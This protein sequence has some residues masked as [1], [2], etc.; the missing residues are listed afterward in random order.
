ME[1]A[2]KK[3]AASIRAA[4]ARFPVYAMERPPVNDQDEVLGPLAPHDQV[5]YDSLTGAAHTNFT[6][7]REGA[8]LFYRACYA[9]VPYDPTAGAYQD[10]WSMV[11]RAMLPRIIG[12]GTHCDTSH[13]PVYLGTKLAPQSAAVHV[14]SGS[15]NDR[16]PDLT[17][18]FVIVGTMG[19]E[20]RPPHTDRSGP[21]LVGWALSNALDLQLPTAYRT[22][23][24]TR[25]QNEMLIFVV[26]AFGALA[27]CC[28]V[29]VFGVLR[30]M[31]LR[32]LRPFLPWIAASVSGAA[33]LIAFLG[34]EM[35]SFYQ[36]KILQPQ[37]CLI[38]LGALLAAGLS[39]IRANQILLDE[40]NQIDAPAS[41]VND[42][43]VFISYAH[44][45]LAWVTQNVY[46]KFRD[47]KRN[48]G[49]A[50]EVF[51]DTKSIRGGA[52][53]QDRISLAIDGS[54]F[55]VPV[56]SEIYFTRPYCRFE[57]RRAHRKWIQA[58]VDSR[59]VMPVMR[60]RP[61][62]D[63]AVDDIEAISIDAQSDIVDQYVAEILAR[64]AARPA[65]GP[66]GG[67]ERPA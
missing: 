51:F 61:R 57:I 30:R 49:T 14:A 43:D 25:P 6:V 44:E 34:F 4:A 19:P 55:I 42:Y 54:R 24:D 8:G 22:V 38:S 1:T 60:G 16:I 29:A 35:L 23:Y 26:P 9:H 2:R 3:L 39:G 58:G 41:E 53:W 11:D 12:M 32:R 10:V 37:V 48:D 33:T 31:R 15:M 5:I 47:A 40:Q 28:F 52:A 59:C 17:D 65:A 66:A 21:E 56:Y 13:I 27:V 64:L 67:D 63:K 45:E 18:Q 36:L 62:I 7:V 20:D 50:L 46:A